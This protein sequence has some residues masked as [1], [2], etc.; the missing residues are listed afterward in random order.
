MLVDQQDSNVLPVLHEV[1]ERYLDL[2][3]LGIVVADKEILLSIGWRCN[4]LGVGS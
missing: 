4:M 3:R 2:R 1:L